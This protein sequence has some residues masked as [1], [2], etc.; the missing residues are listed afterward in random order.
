MS[1]LLAAMRKDSNNIR[2]KFVDVDKLLII[3]QNR[4]WICRIRADEK[5]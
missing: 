2:N 4:I 5:L 3:K 1:V